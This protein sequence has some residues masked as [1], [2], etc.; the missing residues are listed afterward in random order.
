MNKMKLQLE[1][2]QVES[3]AVE[4]D[5]AEAGTVFG[6][7]AAVPP[8]SGQQTQCYTFCANCVSVNPTNCPGDD[9]CALSCFQSC[10]VSQCPDAYTCYDFSCEGFTCYICPVETQPVLPG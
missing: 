5:T 8:G 7:E 2:L 6:L 3:F 9:T 4:S 1:D 10:Q